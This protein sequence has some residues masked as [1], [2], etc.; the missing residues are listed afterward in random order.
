MD[1]RKARN[2]GRCIDNLYL[3]NSRTKGYDHSFILEDTCSDIA[4]ETGQY[5]LT[6]KSDFNAVQVYS[7][8]Y[9]NGVE[10]IGTKGNVYRG[11]AIEPQDNQLF[12]KELKLG[13]T[14]ERYIS[15]TFKR[16]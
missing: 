16:L 14:Y 12:R 7:D 5:L 9:E 13:E 8:N 15:Y 3:Q 11:V 1:F 2:I 10:M 4:L 6:I